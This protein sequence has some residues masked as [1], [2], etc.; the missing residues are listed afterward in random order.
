MTGAELA[1]KFDP[2]GRLTFDPML[3]KY[4]L[5]LRERPRDLISVT[6]AIEEALHGTLGEEYWT[7]LSRERGSRIHEMILLAAQQD[8][9][10]RGLDP[11]LEPYLGALSNFFATE[12]PVVLAAEQPIFDEALGYA[13]TF[14][15]LCILNGPNRAR[16]GDT[17]DLL[18]AKTGA[19]PWTIGLQT[20][21]Y[22]RRIALVYPG[23]RIRRWA[24]HLTP[25]GYNLE[26]VD[27]QADALAHEADF[28]A[29]L[30]TA[31]LRRRHS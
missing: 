29:V 30:R 18:D 15:L 16:I 9:D 6:T 13:G 12:R 14:D 23:I 20:A 27:R 25:R 21:A 19:V 1:T 8:L 17:I 4:T 24:W 2:D 7:D 10:P 31:L 3:H 11:R 26:L 28:L 5:D 22:K